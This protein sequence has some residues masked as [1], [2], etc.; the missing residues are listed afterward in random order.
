MLLCFVLAFIYLFIIRRIVV[1]QLAPLLAIHTHA[2]SLSRTPPARAPQRLVVCGQSQASHWHARRSSATNTSKIMVGLS[3]SLLC[4]DFSAGCQWT[5]GAGEPPL[6]RMRTDRSGLRQRG[7]TVHGRRRAGGGR[8]DPGRRGR[9]RGFVGPPGQLAGARAA[10]GPLLTTGVSERSCRPPL[11]TFCHSLPVV[12]ASTPPL[13]HFHQLPHSFHNTQPSRLARP[14]LRKPA[15]KSF[16]QTLLSL[17]LL[18]TSLA[19]A[20]SLFGEVDDERTLFEKRSLLDKRTMTWV[21]SPVVHS[22]T[23]GPCG[24]R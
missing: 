17:L 9:V 24:W 14:L 16:T 7:G 3:P 21:S 23:R 22:S 10:G 11:L 13:T 4:K 20:A 15:M 18:G 1:L 12:S 2:R 5:A 6:E 19:A 8:K